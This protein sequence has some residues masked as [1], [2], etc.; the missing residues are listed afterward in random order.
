VFWEDGQLV[1][2]R[3]LSSG[4]R[5]DFSRAPSADFGWR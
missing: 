1:L 4:E 5:G 3:V 2:P